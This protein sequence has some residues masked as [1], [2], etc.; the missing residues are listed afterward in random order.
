M[1]ASRE[2]WTTHELELFNDDQ[3][4]PRR[5]SALTADLRRDP[6][7][8]M[9]YGEARRIDEVMRAALHRPR[10]V[11]PM[12][13]APAVRPAV[14]AAS[15]LLSIGAGAWFMA[16]KID[17]RLM[18]SPGP[19]ATTAPPSVRIVFSL[20]VRSVRSVPAQDAH[21]KRT[22]ERT[23]RTWNGLSQVRNR[24]RAGRVNEAVDFLAGASPE[25]RRL[26][27]RYLGELI[28]SAQV[29][30]SILDKLS[31]EEQAAVCGEWALEPA[32]RPTVFERL[33]RLSEDPLV[34]DTMR[35]VLAELAA[36]PALRAWVRGYRLFARS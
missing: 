20:P 15:V 12:L 1:S 8:R 2:A 27:Y 16:S 23:N 25:Q 31:P 19:T 17:H 9:R 28:Q 11:L 4:D 3:L 24:I 10:P 14:A 36:D 29:A 6:A 32:L 33:R 5:A 21:V 18:Q 13:G 26:G 34:S 22:A 30:E 35:S 7:L